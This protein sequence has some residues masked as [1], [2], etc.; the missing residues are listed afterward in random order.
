MLELSIAMQTEAIIL[1]CIHY[2]LVT[3]SQSKFSTGT[4]LKKKKKTQTKKVTHTEL[5]SGTL[6]GRLGS[7]RAVI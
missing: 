4:Y 6:T 3:Q 7:F 1:L 2:D 5:S